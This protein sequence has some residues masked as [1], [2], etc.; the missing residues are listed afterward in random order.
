MTKEITLIYSDA[1]RAENG[2]ETPICIVSQLFTKDGKLVAESKLEK[3]FFK[4][5]EIDFN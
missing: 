2:K 1:K 5:E 4:P 3:S